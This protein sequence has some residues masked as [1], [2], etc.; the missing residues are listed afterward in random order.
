MTR[1]EK[2]AIAYHVRDLAKLLHKDA[3]DEL[4]RH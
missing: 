4:G 2:Q 1:E 3:D